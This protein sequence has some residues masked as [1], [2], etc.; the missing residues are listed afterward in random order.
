MTTFAGGLRA[1]AD[2]LDA[3]PDHAPHII[4]PDRAYLL[5]CGDRAA[6]KAVARSLGKTKKHGDG[7]WFNVTRDFGGGVS[8]EAYTRRENVCR[9]VVTGTQVVPAHT[10]PAR[11]V[12]ESVVE[13]VKWIC[14][15]PILA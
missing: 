5:H 3:N 2:W 14:D 6:L 13:L 12:P 4:D 15:E 7:N 11:N 8:L 1:L 10:E 9:R